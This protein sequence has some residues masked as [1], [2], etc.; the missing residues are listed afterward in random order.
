MCVC[1]CVCV[2]VW[3]LKR[4]ILC[5]FYSYMTRSLTVREFFSRGI[6]LHTLSLLP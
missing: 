6:K 5:L 2:W 4:A 3:V 1:V